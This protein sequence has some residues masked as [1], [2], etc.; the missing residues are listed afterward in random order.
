MGAHEAERPARIVS[1]P[2]PAT[3]D[4]GDHRLASRGKPVNAASL[5][6]PDLFCGPVRRQVFN[7]RRGLHRQ[8]PCLASSPPTTPR[9][10]GGYGVSPATYRPFPLA[11]E[12]Q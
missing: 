9:L 12:A 6:R 11:L 1:L 10:A 8:A 4:F 2:F 5:M 7:I 3:K